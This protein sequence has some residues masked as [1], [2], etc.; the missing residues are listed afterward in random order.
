MFSNEL[1]DIKERKELSFIGTHKM[2]MEQEDDRDD[3]DDENESLE[4]HSVLMATCF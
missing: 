4:G 3:D 2:E 1:E